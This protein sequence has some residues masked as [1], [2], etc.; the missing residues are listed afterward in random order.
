MR[1]LGLDVGDRRIGIA[2]SDELGLTAGLNHVN[3]DN[4]SEDFRRIADIAG[5][6]RPKDYSG[7]AP[8]MNG[9]YGPR[10]EIVKEFVENLLQVYPFEVVYED[11]RL[12][13][14]AAQRTCWKAMSPGVNAD[15][16]W[17]KLPQ[18]LFCKGIWTGAGTRARHCSDQ[19]EGSRC[20]LRQLCR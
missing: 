15:K 20:R 5:N 2:V 8:N 14:M 7:N 11:E 17:I 13:T 16:L 4:R 1:I 12:T 6:M 9:T 18:S 10:T 19:S 3:Q